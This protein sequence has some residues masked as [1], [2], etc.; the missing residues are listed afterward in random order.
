MQSTD[1]F[2]FPLIDPA[3]FTDP[4]DIYAATQAVK[5]ALEFVTAPAWKD[6]IVAPY[7]P[8]ANLSTDADIEA[9][10]R[11]FSTTLFHPV[12]SAYA[13]SASSKEGVV[14]NQLRVKGATGLRVVDASI[15][16]SFAWL[17]DTQFSLTF[18]SQ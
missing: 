10:I 2:D 17:Y 18:L 11:N 7:G 15:F 8:T 14:D 16:V 9:F 13:S 12:G 6:Y 3:Y 5:S 4:Y 1:P